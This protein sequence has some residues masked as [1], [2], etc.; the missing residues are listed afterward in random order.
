MKPFKSR[1][2]A[3]YKGVPAIIAFAKEGRGFRTKRCVKALRR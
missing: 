3:R 2:K 1:R